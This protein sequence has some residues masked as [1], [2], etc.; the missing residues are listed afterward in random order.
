MTE[1][2]S[3]V[4]N[5]NFAI[6]N[7]PSLLYFYS[8][9]DK[10]LNK[11][12]PPFFASCDED[13]IRQV[14]SIVNYSNSLICRF[15]EDYTLYNI[16]FFDEKEGIIRGNRND[17]VINVTEC[18]LLKTEEGLRWSELSKKI[19]E[20]RAQT[21]S[22]VKDYH[23]CLKMLDDFEKKSFVLNTMFDNIERKYPEVEKFYTLKS[24]KK[25]II[26][27]LFSH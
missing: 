10:K 26:R 4:C 22:I 11:F 5:K 1:Q 18:S 2:E 6:V 24:S 13:A 15:P 16:G 17:M 8:I 14:S 12:M 3:Q 7:E 20:D 19:E 9:Y 25:S 23:K 21:A 27:R